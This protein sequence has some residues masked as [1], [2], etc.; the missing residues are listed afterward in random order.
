MIDR[1][2][3]L[4]VLQELY[5]KVLEVCDKVFTTSRPTATEKMDEFV[6]IRLPQGITPY[7]DTHSTAYVQVNCYVRDRQGGI[8]NENVMEEL[9][10]SVISL[11]PFNDA[12]MSC[13]D[14]PLILETKSDGMGF[15]STAIQFKIVIKV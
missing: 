5:E 1:Y 11:I 9:I 6:V 7:A 12:L 10:D 8:A 15:H 14:T 4:D 2:K 13:N 3:R